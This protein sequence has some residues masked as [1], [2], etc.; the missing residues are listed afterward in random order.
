[1]R[2]SLLETFDEIYVLNLHGSSKKQESAPDGTKDDNVFDITVGVAIAL[3]VKLPPGNRRREEGGKKSKPAGKPHATVHHADL[4][5]LR[6]HK[7]D[8]LGGHNAASTEWTSFQADAPD[9]RFVPRN[10]KHEEEWNQWWSVRD[11]FVVS[12]NGIKTERDR[13]SIHFSRKEVERAVHDFRTLSTDELRKRY[14]LEK[15]S[16]DWSVDRAKKDTLEHPGNKLFAPVL[17]RPFDVRYTWFSGRAKGF[18]GTPARELMRHL[19]PNDN[20][21]LCCLRQARR[22]QTDTFFVGRGLVCK[23]IVSIFDI[24]TV[25]P[26]YLYPG[27]EAE[28]QG[29]LVPHENGRRPNLAADF[30]QDFAKRL[31]LEFVPDGRG[32]RK[33]TFGPEDIFNYAYAIFHAPSYRERYAEFLKLGFPRLPLTQDRNLFKRLSEWGQKLVALHTMREC[34][35]FSDVDA[36]FDVPGSN[37][38]EQVIYVPPKAAV[39]KE[40]KA[41]KA[42]QAELSGEPAEEEPERPSLPAGPTGRVYINAKQYFEGILPV[43]WQFRIGGYQVCEKWLKDRKGRALEH[44]DVE[45]YQRTVS[46]LAETR[47]LM[48][49]IDSL[50]A[51]HGGWPLD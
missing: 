44:D 19:F 4:W 47:T 27:G 8:W 33:K 38:V 37:V 11:A 29:E 31:G 32:N 18:I 28:T 48:A 36:C 7:Y 15:D 20:V 35:E 23:D 34:S 50:I 1:M 6:K 17:Y 14:D 42:R 43:V 21:A 45:H 9:F 26:L 22:G 49:Q 12:G 40:A 24:G 10:A 5:G 25:F 51:D 30:V 13:V 41:A 46:A 16:R 3:F 2:E 39:A